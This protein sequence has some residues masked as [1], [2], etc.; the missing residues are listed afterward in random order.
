MRPII[1]LLVL[2]LSFTDCASQTVENS[3]NSTAGITFSLPWINHYRYAD[4]YKDEMRRTFGFFGLGISGYYKKN[5]HKTSFNCSLTEDLPSP[6]ANVNFSKKDITTNIGNAYFELIYHTPIVD[7]VNLIA[8]MNFTNYIFR[9]TSR[10][11]SVS[12][13][14]KIDQTLGFSLGLEYR[15]NNY[16]SVAAVYRPAFASFETDGKYRHLI[17]IELRIDLDLKKK[18]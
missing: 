9:V 13:Y 14:K 4:H 3:I 2:F 6:L 18:D 10:I 15:F 16:Y 7:D 5:K 17:N 1:I 11:D 8:G 12:S